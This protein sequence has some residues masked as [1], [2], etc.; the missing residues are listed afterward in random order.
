MKSTRLATL[1]LA[2][3]L[4]VPI[5]S[6]STP[7]EETDATVQNTP[8][9]TTTE[10]QTETEPVDLYADLGTAD[11]NGYD[12]VILNTEEFKPYMVA[13]EQTGEIVND[14][15]FEANAKVME[16]AN[17]TIRQELVADPNA[18]FKSCVNA[19]DNAFDMAID[20]D[21]N[22]AKRQMGG[23]YMLNLLELPHIQWDK[24]WWPQFTTD[25]LTFNDQMY[26]YSN[27]SSYLGNWFTRAVFVNLAELRNRNVEDL[28]QLVYENKWTLDKWIEITKDIFVDLDGNGE[29][30]VEDFYGFAIS[31]STYC[32]LE[33]WNIEVF[34]KNGADI[35]IDVENETLVNTMEKVYNWFHDNQ[36]VYYS[37]TS[38]DNWSRDSYIGIF[39]AESS[40]STYGVIGRLL[41]G[42]MDTEIEY[43]IL[44]MPMLDE[45]V[46][47][48]YSGTTDRPVSV[49]VTCQDKDMVGYVIEAMAISGY[50]LILP[51]YCDSALKGRYATDEDSTA[52]LDIIFENRVL[53]FSYLYSNEN[54]PQ[55][56]NTLMA[57]NSFD[58]ASYVAKNMS[59]NEAWVQKVVDAYNQ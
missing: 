37:P 3:C 55:M 9:D 39:A 27:Y 54:F 38:I 28:Y 19:G 1:F 12:Y 40:M 2:L 51:A 31:G 10:A 45:S 50:E 22:S 59:S 20:H 46:G 49:P 4:C 16:M 23:N 52:M 35:T 8:T 29:S 13:E 17:L 7:T 53:G 26:M 43:G 25:A 32:W 14:A 44:P 34:Q 11:Y 21:C 15:V 48:Y 30:T 47:K 36:G 56:M 18:T 24:P 42:L 6:C 41:Q 57:S 58:Y 33:A 5:V